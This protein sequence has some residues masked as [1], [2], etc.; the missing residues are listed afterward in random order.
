MG[1][2]EGEKVEGRALRGGGEIKN[3]FSPNLI[4]KVMEGVIVLRGE[5]KK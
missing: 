3:F 2:G 4:I 1:V 5:G